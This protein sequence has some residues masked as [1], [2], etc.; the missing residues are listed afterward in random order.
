MAIEITTHVDAPF[1]GVDP[2]AMAAAMR[3][4]L[5]GP[6]AGLGAE[7]VP[8]PA[9]DLGPLAALVHKIQAMRAEL[10]GRVRSAAAT[11]RCARDR[12]ACRAG[13]AGLDGD[14]SE[15]ALLET[16]PDH[17]VL[18]QSLTRGDAYKNMLDDLDR[19]FGL[20]GEAP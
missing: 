17:V 20:V 5:D 18:A 6:A 9:D 7:P 19:R 16:S 12:I 14:A 4:E 10:V 3:R 8:P 2:A 13:A 15:R 1:P 11:A